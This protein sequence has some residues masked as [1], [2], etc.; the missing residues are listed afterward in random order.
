MYRECEQEYIGEIARMLATRFQEHTDGKHLNSAI[1]EHT[2]STGHRYTL[3]NTKIV[4]GEGGEVVPA[5][6]PR[7]SP[8]SQEI[9]CP[10]PRPWDLPHSSPTPVT[11]H[12]SHVTSHYHHKKTMWRGWNVWVCFKLVSTTLDIRFI[13]SLTWPMHFQYIAAATTTTLDIC[14][15]ASRA[16]PPN[17]SSSSDHI[18]HLFSLCVPRG[19]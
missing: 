11:W 5:K 14:F 15:I 9:P 10:Q 2:S 17:S 4:H 13:Y 12:L 6:D 3:D 16:A 8:H 18:Q 7:S 19:T 1:V